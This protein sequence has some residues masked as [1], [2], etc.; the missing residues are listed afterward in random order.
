MARW[1]LEKPSIPL[2]AALLSLMAL[3]VPVLGSTVFADTASEFEALVWLSALIPAFLLAYYRGWRGVALG[4]AAAMVVMTATQLLIVTPG[5]ELP[6]WHLML[7]ITGS[8][9][10][11]SLMLGGVIEQ[12]HVARERA[13]ELALFD[14]LTGLPNR[15]YFD[16]FFDKDFAAARRGVPLVL[17]EFDIDHFKAFNDRYGHPVGDALLRDFGRVLAENT[18]QMNLSARIG[19]EEFMSLVAA[20]TVEGAIVFVQRVRE[21]LAKI[22]SPEPITVSAGVAAYEHGMTSVADLVK[23]ADVALYRAKELGRDTVVVAGFEQVGAEDA[24]A[25]AVA[26]A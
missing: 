11:I 8:F 23:A 12:L 2:S 4:F 10:G 3:V 26:R 9:I 25:E 13:E 22:Q 1:H 5:G 20:S 15:R 21:G 6:N 19:G 7:A 24:P 16:L 18:R 17:V 14:K